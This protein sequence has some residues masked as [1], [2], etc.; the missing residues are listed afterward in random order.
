MPISDELGPL[1][2]GWELRMAPNGRPYF[3]DHNT[4]TTQFKDPRLE[5]VT[6]SPTEHSNRALQATYIT[7]NGGQ[8]GGGGS[9]SLGRSSTLGSGGTPS[10]HQQHQQQH[11]GS[12]DQHRGSVDSI[13]SCSTLS[14]NLPP[15]SPL[16]PGLTSG[17]HFAEFS[18]AVMPGNGGGPPHSPVPPP[19]FE[20]ETNGGAET[21]QNL[22]SP[23]AITAE[24]NSDWNNDTLIRNNQ[25]N[26]LQNNNNNNNNNT[27]TPR[28][29]SI[30]RT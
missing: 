11:R 8:S 13:N 2:G 6:D 23:V 17:V 26:T 21:P 22:P 24:I 7:A 25:D 18:T 16:T 9:G 20:L 10:E 29:V 27:P 15:P 14:S 12:V 28:L 5:N 30:L 4:K 3:V 19:I 1:P